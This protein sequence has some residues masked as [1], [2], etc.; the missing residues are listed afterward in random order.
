[1]GPENGINLSEVSYFPIEEYVN[2]IKLEDRLLE[3]LEYTN[4]EFQ[5]YIE[6][7]S[8]FDTYSVIYDWVI[9]LF[10]EI[11]FSQNI[12]HHFINPDDMLNNNI[13]FDTLQ[14]SHARIKRLHEFAMGNINIENPED[15]R[16]GDV[17]VSRVVDG[18]EEMIWRG[19]KSEDVKKFMD[20]FVDFY[21]KNSVSLLYSNPFLKSAMAHLLFVRIHP[22][23]DGNGR[24]ARLIHN[25][26]FTQSINSIYGTS[27][28]ISPLN[29][30]QNIL[31]NKITYVNRL[32]D[33][34]FDLEHDSN[35]EINNWLNFV[36]DMVDEQIYYSTNNM[37]KLEN[38]LH[39]SSVSGM[40]PEEAKKRVR[41]MKL[42]KMGLR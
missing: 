21:K 12:E 36:L 33:I 11:K 32:N 26:K 19:A 5:T 16:K 14:I 13:F 25:I 23:R 24:T 9:S 6:Y 4:K 37:S 31:L 42:M 2:K 40:E 7:L 41:S 18:V 34:Y 29:L 8:L 20:D 35:H 17:Y 27:L 15:Y 28:K 1:M 39:L 3:H 22:F 38:Q 10:N 30:S